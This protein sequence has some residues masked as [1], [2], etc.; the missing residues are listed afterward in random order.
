MKQPSTE[1]YATAEKHQVSI[2]K[3][4]ENPMKHYERLER[5]AGNY[6]GIPDQYV[7]PIKHDQPNHNGHF[8]R[9]Q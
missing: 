6:N 9:N 7:Q 2:G 4:I 1:T 3:F 5:P 8:Y